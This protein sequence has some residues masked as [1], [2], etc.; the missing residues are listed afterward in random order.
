MVL[1]ILRVLSSKVCGKGKKG[2]PTKETV[3]IRSIFKPSL[4]QGQARTARIV[5]IVVS[6]FVSAQSRRENRFLGDSV[7]VLDLE[8][9]S[10]A[11]VDGVCLASLNTALSALELTG[12]CGGLDIFRYLSEGFLGPPGPHLIISLNYFL[13]SRNYLRISKIVRVLTSND[14]DRECDLFP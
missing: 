7:A 3:A 10:D 1:I 11:P 2:Q 8:P 4:R 6:F 13:I 9:V 5:S 12:C 14:E